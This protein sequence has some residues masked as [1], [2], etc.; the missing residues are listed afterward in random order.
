MFGIL[1]FSLIARIGFWHCAYMND[2]VNDLLTF[3]TSSMLHAPPP[4]PQF[5]LLIS[6]W[7]AKICCIYIMFWNYNSSLM[8]I[9]FWNGFRSPSLH[10]PF[11][12][13]F[14]DLF[15]ILIF[16]FKKFFSKKKLKD[17]NFLWDISHLRISSILDL[18]FPQ[19]MSSGCTV[20]P[21]SPVEKNIWIYLSFPLRSCFTFYGWVPKTSFFIIK[22]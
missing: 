4:A 5:L 16:L 15:F 18:Y 6:V 8:L 13:Y 9:T 21:H 14:W 7:L 22:F 12:L 10:L 20:F 11:L 17:S 1:T 2:E 19:N 3:P